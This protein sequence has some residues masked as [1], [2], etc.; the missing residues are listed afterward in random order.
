MSKNEQEWKEKLTPKQYE[1]LR[2]NG[3]EAPF[4]GKHLKE[5]RRGMFV[6]AACGSKLFD[7]ST[8]FESGTGWPSFYDVSSSK[9]VKLIEDNSHGM[10]RIE[11]ICAKCGGHLGH[12][13]EDAPNMPTGKRYCINSCALEFEKE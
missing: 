3:T 4:S 7:S 2:E 8:K 11:V 12:M 6:F 9:A 10:K 1:I 5:K 13:F